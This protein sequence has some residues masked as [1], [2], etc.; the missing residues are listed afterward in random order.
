MH[1]LC[2]IAVM[3]QAAAAAVLYMKW[4]W[5]KRARVLLHGVWFRPSDVLDNWM[6]LDFVWQ[7]HKDVLLPFSRYTKKHVFQKIFLLR[8]KLCCWLHISCLFSM[9]IFSKKKKKTAIGMM[10]SNKTQLNSIYKARALQ[11]IFSNC[12][13]ETEYP[14][15]HPKEKFLY[16]SARCLPVLIVKAR[17]FSA[18]SVSGV[19]GTNWARGFAKSCFAKPNPRAAAV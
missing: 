9:F 11:W 17:T 6:L 14:V 8:I 1:A 18:L 5:E 10:L 2:L 4:C 16:Y 15:K 13:S 7:P 19:L 12:W 3:V